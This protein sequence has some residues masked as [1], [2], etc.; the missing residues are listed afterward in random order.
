MRIK[1]MLLDESSVKG[2][3]AI[4]RRWDGETRVILG[5]WIARGSN[6]KQRV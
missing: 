2:S 4:E 1:L 5:C 6:D 3:N